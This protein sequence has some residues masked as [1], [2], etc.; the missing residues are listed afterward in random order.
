MSKPMTAKEIWAARGIA[1]AADALQVVLFPLF[2]GGV[3]EVADA[4]LD[5]AVGVALVWLCGFHAAFL[6]TFVAESLPTV[7]LFP[8]WTLAVF[9]VTRK[10]KSLA[11]SAGA[12]RELQTPD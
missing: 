11:E 3:P 7:D 9:F 12:A 1:L 8:S 5:V 2:A 10:N 4:A 6:P